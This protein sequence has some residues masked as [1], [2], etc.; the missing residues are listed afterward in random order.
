MIAAAP[1]LC[2]GVRASLSLSLPFPRTPSPARWWC[3]VN[4]VVRMMAA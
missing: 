4:V 2:P 1:F 3:G